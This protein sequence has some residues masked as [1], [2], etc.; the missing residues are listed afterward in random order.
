MSG[1][2]GYDGECMRQR[3]DVA[4]PGVDCDRWLA[5]MSHELKQP[6]TELLL[7]AELLLQLTQ[8]P[9]HRRLHVIGEVMRRLVRRQVRIIDDLLEF[10]RART[11]KLPLELSPVDLVAL[12]RESC[13]AAS[14]GMVGMELS[15]EIS[16]ADE[17]RCMADPVRVEQILSNLLGNAVKFS[18]SRGR[19]DVRLV[20]DGGC[21]R[22]SVADAGCG[23]AADFLPHVFDLFDQDRRRHISNTGLGIG[24]SLVRELVLAHGGKVDA[25]SDGP[26]RGACFQVWLPLL[27][28]IAAK[29]VQ[30]P[31]VDA[32]LVR[33]RQHD[34]RADRAVG[35]LAPN[36]ALDS[37]ASIREPEAQP[38]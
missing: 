1:A 13:A 19:I 33:G 24:L 16:G 25:R 14:L 6:L 5:V 27:D 8:E 9:E 32:A 23:I 11:G 36:L 7:N 18:G 20:V 31:A 29:H 3:N 12:V 10:S 38:N 37:V 17:M 2:L 4:R 28:T 30:A 35:M 22:I 34:A 26:G 15:V 21:A